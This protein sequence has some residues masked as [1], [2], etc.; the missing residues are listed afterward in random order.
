MDKGYKDHIDE[1]LEFIAI[2]RRLAEL[3]GTSV[4]EI[5]EF[6]KTHGAKHTEKASKMDKGQILMLLMAKAVLETTGIGRK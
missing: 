3:H 2:V 1:G 5:D 6:I 4:E